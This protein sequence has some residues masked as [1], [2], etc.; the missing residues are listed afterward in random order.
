MLDALCKIAWEW[1][2]LGVFGSCFS[3]FGSKWIKTGFFVCDGFGKTKNL[4]LLTYF[5]KKQVPIALEEPLERW[6]VGTGW[7][8]IRQ[9]SVP[10]S[11][12]G[13]TILLDG[14]FRWL[15]LVRVILFLCISLLCLNACVLQ[16]LELFVNRCFWLIDWL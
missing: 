4:F 9:R 8:Q 7:V 5:G 6:E 14:V 15:F 16:I 13:F 12:L 1:F 3:S 2:R 10:I 11:F